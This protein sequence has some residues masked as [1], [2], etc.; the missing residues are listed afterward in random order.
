MRRRSRMPEMKNGGVNVTPLID[1]VMCM[2]IFFMLVA[3]IGVSTGAE[4][5]EIPA[6]VLG[7]KI[8]DMGNTLTLNVR[9]GVGDEPLVT[10]LIDGKPC[11]FAAGQR[12]PAGAPQL[13]AVLAA[14]QKKNP[15]FK[16][17]I[18]GEKEMAYRYLEPV[19]AACSQANVAR[20]NFNTKL[21]TVESADQTR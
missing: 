10:A 4:P 5:M 2:I 21:V 14:L 12:G 11:R 6:T 1:I 3:R 7:T 9:A 8:D 18:R 13:A 17:I 16:V 15:E 20:V 19:L